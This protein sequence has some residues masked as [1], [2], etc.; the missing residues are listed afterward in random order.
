MNCTGEMDTESRRA[1]QPVWTWQIRPPPKAQSRSPLSDDFRWLLGRQLETLES[2]S[3][4]E[5]ILN[6]LV[7]CNDDW[8]ILMVGKLELD[9]IEAMKIHDRS[10][11]DKI[12]GFRALDRT[13]N[14]L[15]GS[16]CAM[17]CLACP[18]SIRELFKQRGRCEWCDIQQP[19]VQPEI[20]WDHSIAM[21]QSGRGQVEYEQ[22][23]QISNKLNK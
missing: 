14:G 20:F 23:T 6:S 10:A 17:G 9:L 2:S 13:S 7:P 1:P 22:K 18:D 15:P 5:A 21:Q 11:Q 8:W 16:A 4:I 12:R 19:D 3:H